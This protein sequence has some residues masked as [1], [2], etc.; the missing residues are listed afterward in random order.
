MEQYAQINEMFW[1]GSPFQWIFYASVLLI[2][3]FEKRKVHRIVF[4]V[5]PLVMLVAMFNPVSY[6]LVTAVLRRSDKYYVRLFSVIPVFYCMAYGFVLVLNK[7]QGMVKL[8]GVCVAVGFIVFTG[9]CLYREP[10]MQRA[11]NLQK[12]PNEVL[13]VLEAIPRKKENTCVA[14]PDPLY[15]YARQV[16]GSIIMPYGRQLGGVS[17]PLLEAL[18]EPIP[19][20]NAVMSMAGNSNVDYIA[21]NKSEEAKS[22]FSEV[23]YKPVGETEAY[24]IYAVTGVPK[25]VLTLNDKRQ[26]LSSAACDE[27]GNLRNVGSVVVAKTEYEYDQWGNRTRETYFDKE[28]QRVTTIDGYSSRI[29]TF[30]RYGL[31][32][33]ADSTK[34]LDAQDQLVLVYG[35]YETRQR[36]L[37]RREL[38]EERYFDRDGQPMN[39]LDTGYAAMVK[40]FDVLGRVISESFSDTSG[41]PV[42]SVDGYAKYT[43]ELD[44]KNRIVEERYYDTKGDPINNSAG[45]AKQI[46]SYG[47]KGVIKKES[48]FDEEGKAVDIRNRLKQEVS[49]DL[50]QRARRESVTNSVGIGY[51]WNADGTCTVKGYTKGISW[52]SMVEGNRPYYLINGETYRVKYASENVYLN[53][54]FYENNDWNNRIDMLSTLSDAEFT[55]PKNC[56]AIIIRLWVAPGTSVN[57][58]VC[59]R[60]YIKTDRK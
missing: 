42:L 14:L 58:T 43:R 2:L 28:G 35:R 36:F 25:T 6:G 52:N 34:Y 33:I 5:F 38:F 22:A 40:Q 46:I 18:N 49:L 26:T 32:W 29:R 31:S 9:K 54:Y 12:T 57:E 27:N 47:K 60:I 21:V 16:D 39:R 8:T 50:L 15:V 11:E 55:V 19:D 24:C 13:R 23:G 53:I 17:I 30:R 7:A 37:K 56:G 59:P 3:I 1:D 20:V 44:N 41:A 48:F 10:W 4:G 45:Y 51:S